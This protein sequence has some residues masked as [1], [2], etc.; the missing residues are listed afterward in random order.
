MPFGK[1]RGRPLDQLPTSYLRWLATLD[2]L[3]PPLPDEVRQE[4]ERRAGENVPRTRVDPCPDMTVADELITAGLH[5]LARRCHPDVGGEHNAMV[6]V[7]NVVDWLR[8]KIRNHA[9]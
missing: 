2:D 9:R 8:R 4:L 5:N 7:N 3:R 6:T 1:Y